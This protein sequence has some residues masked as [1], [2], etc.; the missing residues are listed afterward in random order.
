MN[1]SNQNKTKGTINSHVQMPKSVLRK[2]E[3]NHR[4]CYYDVQK[5]IIGNGG[6]ANSINTEPDYYSHEM[7]ITLNNEYE[8][9]FINTV[10]Y[11]IKAL[12]KEEPFEVSSH[13]VETIYSF[14]YALIA[15]S[16]KLFSI[17]NENMIH[18]QFSNI[19]I[20]KQHDNIVY[21]ALTIEKN[22]NY[23][24]EFFVSFLKNNSNIP[25]VLPIRGMY[26]I[27]LRNYHVIVMPIHP[28][29]AVLLV[30][31][32]LLSEFIH[33]DQNHPMYIDNPNIIFNL[34]LRAFK[35]QCSDEWGYVVSSDKSLLENLKQKAK[36]EIVTNSL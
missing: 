17:A 34:N 7:E 35:D 28:Y 14:F 19:P 9:G 5:G 32:N 1:N 10:N 15:R 24:K 22:N 16:P 11:I 25:F 2:F 4:L 12:E 8:T 27:L 3:V 21:S 31:N 29:Y 33:D 18:A 23:G 30:H 6:S 26:N 13:Q 36:E 20:R